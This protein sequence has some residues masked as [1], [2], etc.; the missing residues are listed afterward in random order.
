[1][2]EGIV[3]GRLCLVDEEEPADDDLRGRQRCPE[4]AGDSLIGWRAE[5]C[6]QIAV[7]LSFT[8]P[9]AA[10]REHRKRHNRETEKFTLDR[11]AKRPVREIRARFPHFALGEAD[12]QSFVQ[13]RLVQGQ[14]SRR[15]LQPVPVGVVKREHDQQQG[16]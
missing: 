10:S 7:E 1:M 14:S 5:K 13:L 3:P 4:P 9:L 16:L 6:A 2:Q 8:D 12:Q 11:V 15:L